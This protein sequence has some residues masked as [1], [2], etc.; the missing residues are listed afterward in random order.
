MKIKLLHTLFVLGLS[1]VVIAQQPQVIYHETFGV[2]AGNQKVNTYND[3]DHPEV[4]YFSENN[5]TDIRTSNASSINQY[6]M[7]SG[8]GN[9]MI[10]SPD[11]NLIVTDVD[12]TNYTDLSFS[13]GLRKGTTAS[14]G[15][16]MLVTLYFDSDTVE[17][18]PVLPTGSGTATYHWIT[19][20]ES[21][22]RASNTFGMKFEKL[23]AGAN[24]EFRLDDFYLTGLYDE[25]QPITLTHFSVQQQQDQLVFDWAT[26]M[27]KEVSHYI[28]EHSVDGKE[29]SALYMETAKN[30]ALGAEYEVM[31]TTEDLMNN[32]YFRLKSVDF[33]GEFDYSKVVSLNIRQDKVW[34]NIPNYYRSY[35][36]IDLSNLG[37]GKATV[38]DLSGRVL[39]SSSAEQQ[40]MSLFHLSQQTY[41]LV[42]EDEVGN[43]Y[44]KQILI[45]P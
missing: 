18:T 39:L 33:S 42:F 21:Y 13:F 25:A 4:N 17:F 2:P 40:S 36:T 29:F 8:G 34:N 7:A 26:S 12:V 1:T 28:I 22:M 20:P 38:Y 9:V 5:L 24:P 43:T 27:E 41:I 30:S 44:S 32:N 10:N 35:Q 14:D 45:M 19:I 31:T 3:Y 16:E 23:N 37:R 15:S 11:K 6:P